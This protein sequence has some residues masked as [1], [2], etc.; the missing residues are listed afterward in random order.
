MERK[1]EKEMKLLDFSWLTSG[2]GKKKK[3]LPALIDMAPFLFGYTVVGI[4]IMYMPIFLGMLIG[5]ISGNTN[6]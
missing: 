6:N 5:A 4:L 2:D 3:L 1:E